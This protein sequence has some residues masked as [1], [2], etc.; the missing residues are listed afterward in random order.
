ME[1]IDSH[2]HF[3]PAPGVQYDW[4][5]AEPKIAAPHGP[6]EYQLESAA[7][8]EAGLQLRG[9]VFVEAG[10][11]PAQ[12]LAE[13]KWVASLAQEA[14]DGT[15]R[16]QE[17]PILGI[18]AH[19]SLELGVAIRP[20]LALLA[21]M[22]GDKKESPDTKESPDMKESPVVGIRRNYQEEAPG[23]ARQPSF[24][25]GLRALPDFGFTH[26]LCIHWHQIE[27]TI[28]LV[29]RCPEVQFILDHCAKPAITTPRPPD[30]D[31]RWRA[32]MR[33][34]AARPNV[35]CKLSGLVTEADHARWQTADLWPYLD[36][37][38]EV[39]G[40]ERLLFGSDWPVVTL[41]SSWSR[42]LATL[43]EA[44]VGLSEA[45]QSAIF[46]GNARRVYGLG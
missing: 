38:L 11:T 43:R 22:R 25:R 28:E 1:L 39:F 44:L 5:E 10:R 20:S 15:S 30:A 12:G 24:A 14:R 31:R 17:A 18:V 42:W 8:R 33:A 21:K 13:A 41:A 46:A 29:A 7:A 26:D 34:L 36:Y 3:W 32:G 27:E 9:L 45:E 16:P 37:A 40:T 4:L 2:V 35:V 6:R 23:F 19:A